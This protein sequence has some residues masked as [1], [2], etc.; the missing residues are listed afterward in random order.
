M[1][2]TRAV[3]G[4]TAHQNKMAVAI[5][6]IDISLFIDLKPDA[7]MAQGG[8]YLSTAVTCDTRF[9]DSDYFRVVVIHLRRLA[10]PKRGCNGTEKFDY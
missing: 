10:K 2:L 5:T 4:W 1:A 8:R 7:G 9:A 6:A 3:V